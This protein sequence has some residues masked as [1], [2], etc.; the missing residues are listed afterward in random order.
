MI[1]ANHGLIRQ[2]KSETVFPRAAHD[3]YYGW[4]SVH[5]LSPI[6]QTLPILIS[7]MF[8]V[9]KWLK[10]ITMKSLYFQHLDLDD[11]SFR[12]YGSTF[13]KD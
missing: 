5:V 7:L 3:C 8:R 6:K 12:L 2:R 4:G 9:I 10:D 11:K 13:Q 1:I